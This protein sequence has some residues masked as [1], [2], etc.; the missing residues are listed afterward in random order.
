[1]PEI[2]DLVFWGSVFWVLGVILPACSV[3]EDV[4]VDPVVHL[5]LVPDENSTRHSEGDLIRLRGGSLFLAWTR[6]VSGVGGDFIYF[7]F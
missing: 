7:Q 2:I 6:F 1:V 4:P 5:R 3:Q